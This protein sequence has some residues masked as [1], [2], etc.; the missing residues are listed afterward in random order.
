MPHSLRQRR[1]LM[2]KLLSLLLALTMLI[3]PCA[4]AESAEDA[5]NTEATEEIE[6]QLVEDA[7]AG[8]RYNLPADWIVLSAAAIE[9]MLAAGME[10]EEVES[11]LSDELIAQVEV[12]TQSGISMSMSADMLSN[13]NILVSPASGMTTQMLYDSKDVL[14]E[15]YK[16]QESQG[17]T[18]ESDGLLATFG[19]RDF[20]SI[21]CT[22]LEQSMDV[23]MFIENDM[24]YTITFTNATPEVEE[25]M[26]SSIEVVPVEDSADEAED[27][28]AEAEDATGSATVETEESAAPEE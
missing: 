10:T 5:E 23:Y 13:V 20:M 18:L 25:V 12:L 3:L 4:F 9:S 27:T 19:E 1:T 7:I 28:T 8:L 6:V 17:L 2:K 22:M 16:A 26:L 24:M 15:S 11:A 21:S 14:L